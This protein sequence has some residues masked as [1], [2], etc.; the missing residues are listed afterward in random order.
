MREGAMYNDNPP[1]VVR[2]YT[3]GRLPRIGEVVIVA[4]FSG[5]CKSHIGR[6]VALFPGTREYDVE[7][8]DENETSR[9]ME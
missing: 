8:E 4:N 2:L 9:A 7:L 3:T 1:R 6:V 5:D